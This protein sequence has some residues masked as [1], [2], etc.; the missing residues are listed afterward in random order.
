MRRIALFL[1]LVL[2]AG[3]APGNVVKTIDDGKL[4]VYCSFYPM[5]DFAQ[6]IG[7]DKIE[8]LSIAAVGVEPH[9]FEPTAADIAGL[10]NA[11]LFIYNGLDMEP[12]ADDALISLGA[13]APPSV[14]AAHGIAPLE[15]AEHEEEHAGEHEEDHEEAHEDEQAE[16]EHAGHDHGGSD[17]HV[18][19]DPMLAKQQMAAIRDALAGVDPAN[20]DYYSQN[21]EKY[22][23]ELDALDTEY[24]TALAPYAGRDIIVAHEA[25]GYLC[26]AYGLVQTPI[27]GLSPDSEPDP[28]R[29]VEIIEHAQEH[30]I[31]VIFFE[32]MVSPKVAETIAEAVGARCEELNPLEGLSAEELASG[33]DYFSVM[34]EN[35]AALLG[36]FE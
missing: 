16:D 28:A 11:G 17:P 2:L 36:A 14:E 31:T 9:D 12:W 13:D 24:N 25:F 26:A 29:M 23:A 8:A 18:W 7:G 22:A 4:L 33:G 34:R 10:K 1:A 5:Y 35:L 6:K 15:P 19:L 3:C 21:Y 30:G 32:E 20:S 27:E